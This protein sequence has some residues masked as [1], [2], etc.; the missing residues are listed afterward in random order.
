MNR[1]FPYIVLSASLALAVTAAYYSVFGLSKLFSA[2][3]T[4][5]IVMASI[6]E[7]SKLVTASYLHRKWK[8]THWFSKTYLTLALI[9]LMLI[10][11]L[12]IYGFLV[13]AYQETAYAMKNVDQQ[14]AV[15]Q[16][17]KDRWSTQIQNIQLEKESL[18]KSISDL[19][20]GLANN[21]ITYTD[22]NG[23]V[24][25]TTS[26]STRRSLERQLEQNTARRD[27]LYSKEVALTDSVTNCDMQILDLQTNSD[28]AAELGPIKYVAELSGKST[29]NIV[30]KFILLFIF[31]FDPLAVMLL[32]AANQ[33]LTRDNS[34]NFSIEP[35]PIVVENEVVHEEEQE[36]TDIADQNDVQKVYQEFLN[37]KQSADTT[38]ESK[39]IQNPTPAPTTVIQQPGPP[40]PGLHNL[41]RTAAR[42]KSK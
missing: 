8:V 6:L 23:N 38:T 42:K 21:V 33:L 3:A 39:T 29:D 31:V 37:K 13:S 9:V 12:G 2:Q 22:A 15:I 25:R 40:K 26:S 41:W 34:N 18:N 14:T 10:T 24:I 17:K 1:Y 28:A 36:E 19:T 5:V 32:I 27:V 20:A 7:G 11:S 4:A 16:L 30:N 35:E